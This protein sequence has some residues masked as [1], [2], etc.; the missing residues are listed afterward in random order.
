MSPVALLVNVGRVDA[1]KAA[2]VESE[3]VGLFRTEVLYL[4]RSTAPPVEVEAY[5]AVFE[6]FARRKVVIRTLDAGAGKPLPFVRH[7]HEAK[8]ALGVRGLRVARH[9]PELLKDQLAAI[10]EACSGSSA[11]VWVMAPMLSTRLEAAEF[12]EQARAFGLA[13]VGEMIEIPA[14][15]L[16]AGPAAAISRFRQHRHEPS[17]SVHVGSRSHG[18]GTCRPSRHLATGPPRPRRRG[19]RGGPSDEPAG[20]S[21]R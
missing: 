19:C 4:S 6:A 1:L 5:R 21:L 10:A 11:E 17:G 20:R 3:G 16:R 9:Q 18:G 15:A 8:P 7:G 13:T 14:A 2:A 12:T